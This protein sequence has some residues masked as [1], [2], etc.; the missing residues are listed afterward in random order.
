[1][2]STLDISGIV[3]ESIV[4][5]PGVR[6]VIFVQGCPHNC[7]GCHNPQTH[8][9]G[10]GTQTE[11]SELYQKIRENPFVRGVTFSGGEPFCQAQ[12]LATLGDWLRRDGYDIVVYSGFTLEVLLQKA[13]TDLG[14]KALLSAANYLIDGPFVENE[15]DLSLK[16]RGSRNQKIY[17]VTC[18]PNSK[19]IFETEEFK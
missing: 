17:D 18:Y 5:G 19:R 8:P 3:E 9:F 2:M 11:I 12:P 7:R 6:F 1:M 4:D 13:E 14:I 15:K 10:I 16:F